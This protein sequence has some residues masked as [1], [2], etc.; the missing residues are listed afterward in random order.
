MTPDEIKQQAEQ[1]A[2]QSYSYWQKAK[3]FTRNNPGNVLGLVVLIIFVIGVIK[4][5]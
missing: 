1:T 3:D 4:L 2:A 5:G